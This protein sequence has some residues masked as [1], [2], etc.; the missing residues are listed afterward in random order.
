MKIKL[1]LKKLILNQL[2][3]KIFFN[4]KRHITKFG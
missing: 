4:S 2:K 1:E 3:I